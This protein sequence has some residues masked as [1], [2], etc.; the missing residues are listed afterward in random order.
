MYEELMNVLKLTVPAR[1]PG[2][3]PPPE[4]RRTR[5]GMNARSFKCNVMHV[6]MQDDETDVFYDGDATPS[7][8]RRD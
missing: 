3:A 6:P 4:A 1:R 7:R 2:S 8:I 5:T